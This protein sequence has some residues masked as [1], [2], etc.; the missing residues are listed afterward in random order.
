MLSGFKGTIRR[1]KISDNGKPIGSILDMDVLSNHNHLGHVQFRSE[2][3]PDIGSR[4]VVPESTFNLSA[5]KPE[6]I[7]EKLT[8]RKCGRNCILLI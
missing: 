1:P 2:G 5:Y 7:P 6:D 4:A 3:Q 8:V